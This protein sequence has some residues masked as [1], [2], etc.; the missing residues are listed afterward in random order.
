M[1]RSL[2][3]VSLLLLPSLAA[4]PVWAQD[5]PVKDDPLVRMPGS[6]PAPEG[7]VAMEAPG[8]CLNCHAG[9]NTEVEPGFNWKG[10]MMAQAARDFLFYACMTTAAQDSAYAIGR[11][12]A[13]DICLRC[14]FPKGWLEGRSDPT[15]AAAMTGADYDGVQCDFCHTSFDPFFEETYAGAREGNDWLGYWDETNASSTPSAPAATETYAE[16]QAQAQGVQLFNGD[17]FFEANLTPA[18]YDEHASG[19]YFV[20]TGSQ[21]RASFADAAARHQML[22]SRHHKSK[23]FCATCHDVSNPI[24]AN[25]LLGTLYFHQGTID[26]AIERYDMALAHAPGFV[27][28]H[29]DLG[30]AWYH[31]GN[32]PEAIRSFRKCLEIDPHY[33]AAHYRLA[34][35]LFHVGR[36]GSALEH[37]EEAAALTPEYMMANYHMG[38]IHERRNETEEAARSFQRSIDEAVGEVSSIYHLAIIRQ[39]EGNLEEAEELLDRTREF[40]QANDIAA[41]TTGRRQ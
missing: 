13:T 15:N 4:V 37:F 22:Y 32:M 3:L 20:S 29:Y 33:N 18:S 27:L 41:N 8:R 10:S 34:L 11:P 2:L 1:K 24:L 9:Y 5:I 25:H 23:Y 39:A 28:C 17:P 38:V 35:S 31:R 16:D 14:H 36:L 21:K 30:V 40:A 26:L 19:Q 6:Q 12:N 7:G